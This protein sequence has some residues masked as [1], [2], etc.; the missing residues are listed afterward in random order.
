MITG[1]KEK[2]Q[3][4]RL[5]GELIIRLPQKTRFEEM[6]LNTLWSGQ[7]REGITVTFTEV[8]RGMFPGFSL[9]VEGDLE[10]LVNLHGIGADGTQITASPIN[11]QSGGYW[12][13]TLPFGHGI[14][15]IEL[16]IAE[17]QKTFRYPFNFKVKYPE[18]SK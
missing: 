10:K 4:D 6:A 17:E 14:K 11:F 12:T 13:M 1:L 16:I 15:N 18:K 2:E 8:A 7:S 9:K 3:L 5:T